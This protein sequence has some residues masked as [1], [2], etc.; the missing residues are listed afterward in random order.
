[1][2]SLESCSLYSLAENVWDRWQRINR[3]SMILPKG[4][5][6]VSPGQFPGPSTSKDNLQCPGWLKKEWPALP[7]KSEWIYAWDLQRNQHAS[8]WVLGFA[9]VSSHWAQSVNTETF[10]TINSQS[11][12]YL[13]YLIS[14][15]A[16]DMTKSKIQHQS[17]TISCSNL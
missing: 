13:T 6:H 16:P 11:C 3:Q 2:Q 8:F 10:K 17:W 5:W 9:P 7:S 12:F 1:M 15:L 4:R 14:L